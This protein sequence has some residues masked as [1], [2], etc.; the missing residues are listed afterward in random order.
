MEQKD[1]QDSKFKEFFEKLVEQNKIVLVN[2]LLQTKTDRD[3]LKI[4]KQEY[5]VPGESTEKTL[6][7]SKKLLLKIEKHLDS[8]SKTYKKTNDK[9]INKLDEIAKNG[10]ERSEFKKSAQGMADDRPL[11]VKEMLKGTVAS[12]KDMGSKLAKRSGSAFAGIKE[13][14]ASPMQTLDK[15]Q[16]AVSSKIKAGVDYTKDIISTD[17]SYSIEGERFAK[18]RMA[19]GKGYEGGLQKG[20]GVYN[21]KQI[22]EQQISEI[23]KKE[24]VQKTYGFDL[25]QKDKT[26]LKSVEQEHSEI[27]ILPTEVD[28]RTLSGKDQ[29]K[30]LKRRRSDDINSDNFLE[31]TAPIKSKFQ[32][33]L[34]E[35]TQQSS[36]ESPP[37][38]LIQPVKESP[39]QQE[40]EKTVEAK[41]QENPEADNVTSSQEIL[42]DNSKEDIQLTKDLL[43]TTKESVTILKD[44]RQALSDQVEPLRS[45]EQPQQAQPDGETGTGSLLGTAMDLGADL[46]D[47]GKGKA[48]KGVPKGAG[49][50]SL[51]SRM[52]GGI[53]GIGSKLGGIGGIAKGA[54]GVLGKLAVPLAV[55]TAG[56][57]AYK[58]VE[59]AGEN[60]D[61]KEGEEATLGQKTSSAL[62]SVASGFSFGMVD[63]KAAAQGINKAGSAVKDF[64]GFGEDKKAGAAGGKIPG[65]GQITDP[66]APGYNADAAE[67]QRDKESI[68]AAAKPAETVA[69][70]KGSIRADDQKLISEGKTVK[71]EVD[72]TGAQKA[73]IIPGG[74]QITDP[75]ASGYNADAAEYQRD[76]QNIIAKDK[77]AETVAGKATDKPAGDVKETKE[78][79]STA[80]VR[81]AGEAV[82]KTLSNKQMAVI[83]SSKAA[84]NKYSPEV[85]A[86]YAKQK[87]STAVAPAK[88]APVGTDV[89]KESTAKETMSPAAAVSPDPQ[90][91]KDIIEHKARAKENPNVT[92]SKRAPSELNDLSIKYND[93]TRESAQSKPTPA[94]IIMNNSS[95]NSSTQI[96][97][98]KADPRAN[99]RGSA[100]EK[101]MERTANY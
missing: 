84:G 44:I 92:P 18:A 65:G 62:G 48:G 53:K 6:V 91:E 76:K 80:P 100:L 85:E 40:A 37:L 64:F 63:E 95:N 47:G 83:T 11:S 8:T 2:E 67:Y 75:N 14:V 15:A 35:K 57:D 61:L 78:K 89:Q 22:K 101:Y 58:G 54:A 82:G 5:N 56:Y 66:N 68:L 88:A 26:R 33:Q 90:L 4:Q 16:A 94:P 21:A 3:S 9:V 46:L 98:M 12:I 87:E 32:Q 50:P 74:G 70:K 36:I 19:S 25:S 28:G 23:K 41:R 1:Q 10:I 31:E 17:Q 55:A 45:K 99:S 34:K 73:G 52:M 71:T 59:R 69:G 24:D 39:A 27:D 79:A 30:V 29:R 81:I 43:E 20:I 7:E 51:G 72:K 96:M 93:E 86:Q 38:S 60:F 97:P 77:P 49:K 42:A 13:A